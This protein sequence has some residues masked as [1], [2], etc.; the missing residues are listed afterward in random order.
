MAGM[1]YRAIATVYTSPMLLWCTEPW[2]PTLPGLWNAA[3]A[4]DLL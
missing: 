2:Q 3:K 1:V 4:K